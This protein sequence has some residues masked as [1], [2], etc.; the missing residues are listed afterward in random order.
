VNQFFTESPDHPAIIM[1]QSIEHFVAPYMVRSIMPVVT[2]GLNDQTSLFKHEVWLKAPKHRLVHL[3]LQSVLC[4]RIVENSL[5]ACH[6][7]W[8]MIEKPSYSES[9]PCLRRYIMTLQRLRYVLAMLLRVGFAAFTKRYLLRYCLF[10][11]RNSPM[12]SVSLRHL[13]SRFNRRVF[14]KE[15]MGESL[16]PLGIFAAAFKSAFA[17]ALSNL[18]APH[19][20]SCWHRCHY[21]NLKV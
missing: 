9:L 19:V 8:Q 10:P 2:V 14:S 16:T 6:F 11:F 5:Y 13:V 3:E 12:R 21:S 20:D 15:T 17:D 1:G 4:E 18:W 7:D